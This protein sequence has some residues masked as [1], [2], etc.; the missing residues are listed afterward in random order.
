M[1]FATRNVKLSSCTASSSQRTSHAAP[2]TPTRHV[3]V[4]RGIRQVFR[5]SGDLN[6]HACAI[7]FIAVDSTHHSIQGEL[8]DL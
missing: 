6:Q 8:F 5:C 7:A 2:M 3:R 1:A 4:A